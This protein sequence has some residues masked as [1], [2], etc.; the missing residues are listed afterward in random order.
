MIFLVRPW[1]AQNR[2]LAS[3]TLHTTPSAVFSASIRQLKR[4]IILYQLHYPESRYHPW[5]NPAVINVAHSV[6]TTS[7]IDPEWRFY[8]LICLQA[9]RHL[10]LAYPFAAISYKAVLTMAMAEGKLSGSK[11]RDLY[12]QLMHGEGRERVRE[13]RNLRAYMDLSHEGVGVAETLAGDFDRLALVRD[14]EPGGV[15]SA[16]TVEEEEEWP[17]L[18]RDA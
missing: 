10:A 11:A 9:Y 1:L 7:P 8:F 18:H 15:E 6:L 13:A 4:I 5:W 2:P 3:P 12:R 17:S 14:E 16:T